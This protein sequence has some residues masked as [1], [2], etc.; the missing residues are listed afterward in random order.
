ML[1]HSRRYLLLM[2]CM[3]ILLTFSSIGTENVMCFSE[4]SSK[5][6]MCPLNSSPSSFMKNGDHSLIHCENVYYCNL[7]MVIS[8]IHYGNLFRYTLF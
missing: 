4:F 8:L 1:V 3:S 7:I 5:Q 6:V 2:F